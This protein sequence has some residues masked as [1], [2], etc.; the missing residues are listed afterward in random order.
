MTLTFDKIFCFARF[1]SCVCVMRLILIL[2]Q[3]AGCALAGGTFKI[4]PV[5]F[6]FNDDFMPAS[7]NVNNFKRCGIFR[8]KVL[9]PETQT[10]KN[11]LEE[12]TPSAPN[13]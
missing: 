4:S 5:G 6:S 8:G 3:A 2:P 10:N 1:V 11:R 12:R 9:Q 13:P 7:P